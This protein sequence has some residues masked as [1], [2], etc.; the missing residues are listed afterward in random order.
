ML[1]DVATCWT[2]SKKFRWRLFDRPDEY[3]PSISA[4]AGDE[5]EGASG[6]QLTTEGQMTTLVRP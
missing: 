3:V 2:G 6:G 1:Q 5:N 4:T